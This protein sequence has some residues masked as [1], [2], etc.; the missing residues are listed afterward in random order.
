M[1]RKFSMP[2]QETTALLF[3]DMQERLLG[4]MPES[5][6]ATVAKQKIL[7]KAAEILKL[8]VVVTE[9]YPKGLGHTAEEL[10][11]LFTPEW[12]VIEKSTFSSMG[13]AAVRAELNSR[14]IESVVLAGI[15]AHV[16]VLQTAVECLE[17]GYQTILLTDAVN[18][19]NS[20]DM[21]TALMTAQSAGAVLMT[22]ES[23][24]FMLMRDSRHQAF[25]SVAGLLR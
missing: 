19:R 16:C 6:S 10:K 14:R 18:S 24:L 11:T 8:K 13:E 12:P 5:I 15:E 3:I 25:R 7:L 23:L 9:Q 1:K 21:D 20:C 4:A 2:E 17:K 22:V